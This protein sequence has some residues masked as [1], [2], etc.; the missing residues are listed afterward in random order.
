[1]LKSGNEWMNVENISDAIEFL[2]ALFYKLK[3]QHF[4]KYLLMSI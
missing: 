1:M 4:S 2:S 3:F